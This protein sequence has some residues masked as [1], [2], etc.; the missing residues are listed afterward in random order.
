LLADI[1]SVKFGHGLII[2]LEEESREWNDEVQLGSIIF[3][4]INGIFYLRKS[5]LRVKN[6]HSEKGR[7]R[8]AAEE[9]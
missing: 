9:I 6:D 1:L 4:H 2:A 3:P 5:L 8:E 7:L